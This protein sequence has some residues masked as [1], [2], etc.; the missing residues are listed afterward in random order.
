MPIPALPATIPYKWIGVALAALAVVA[1][2]FFAVRGYGNAKYE[3]GVLA[4][5]AV[6]EKAEQE[7][8]ERARQAGVKATEA[9]RERQDEYERVEQEERVRINEALERGESPF[10]SMFG[11]GDAGAGGVR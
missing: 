9:E 5:R 1:L 6:H 4:E 3:A 2:I 7:M 11:F 10:D 8:L